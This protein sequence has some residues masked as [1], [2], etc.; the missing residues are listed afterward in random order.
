MLSGNDIASVAF[1][2]CKFGNELEIGI[3]TSENYRGMGFAKHLCRAMLAYCKS[4]G[5]SPIWA[6][7]KENISS[8]KLA[9]SLGFEESLILPYYEMVK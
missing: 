1:S 6:C 5:Y 4:N 7:R 9:K 8:Y 3:E 2:S